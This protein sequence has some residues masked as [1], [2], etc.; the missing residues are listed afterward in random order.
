VNSRGV[1]RV[2]QHPVL[3]HGIR[4]RAAE[5]RPGGAIRRRKE[6]HA[7]RFVLLQSFSSRREMNVV[8]EL[9]ER[10]SQPYYALGLNLRRQGLKPG[11]RPA[12]AS[13]DKPAR[14]GRDCTVFE[15]VRSMRFP[16]HSAPP[17]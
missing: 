5:S 4:L 2:N 9:R 11:L 15:A 13:W 10:E 17:Y 7:S 1:G 12:F 16:N 6:R 14:S 8:E 3:E